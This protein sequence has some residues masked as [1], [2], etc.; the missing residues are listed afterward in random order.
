VSTFEFH[1]PT[2]VA[3]AVA[4]VKNAGEGKFL[5]G[6][7]S[8]L[9]VIK[10]HLAE[11]SD[12]VTI[13]GL[14]ELRGIRREGDRLIIGATTT[15]AEVA[16]SSEVRSAIPALSSLARGIGDP[17]V[18][19]RGT[20]GGSIAH[21]DPAADYPAALLGLDAK[22]KTNTRTIA[23]DEFFTGM[24]A[25]ALDPAELIL[26][27]SFAVPKRAGYLKFRNQ[28]SLFA[29]VGVMVAEYAGGVRV[30][31]TGAASSVFRSTPL[32]QA[33]TRS[34]TA[35]AV[36]GVAIDTSDLV[37]DLQAGAEYRGHLITVMTK[38]VL[39]VAT[40]G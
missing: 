24:F 40:R 13:A 37:S 1:R 2:S 22:I 20:L 39:A 36:D 33:L 34:F 10:L 35:D 27:V 25:T 30:A 38:R 4:A 15:H 19:N 3:D 11:P 12:L 17:Q 32:E 7:Q 31:I 5:A 26:E 18:R 14:D 29:I 16:A 28:S 8:L 23:A 6:G 9:P 21:N